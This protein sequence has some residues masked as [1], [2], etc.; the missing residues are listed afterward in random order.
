MRIDSVVSERRRTAVAAVLA[1]VGHAAAAVGLAF[2][3]APHAFFSRDLRG[4]DTHTVEITFIEEAAFA[5]GAAPSGSA[6]G[7]VPPSVPGYTEDSALQSDVAASTAASRMNVVT[8]TTAALALQPS[9][10]PSGSN[11]DAARGRAVPPTAHAVESSGQS[12]SLA[13]LGLEPGS[14]VALPRRNP[15]MGSKRSGRVLDAEARL[16]RS[17][18]EGAAT[19]D[20]NLGLGSHGA[21][22]S[23]LESTTLGASTPAAGTALFVARVDSSGKLTFLDVVESNGATAGWADVARRTRA[24]LSARR[25]RV[26]AGGRGV[27]LK[28]RVRSRVQMPSGA[29]PGLEVRALGIPLK[30]GEGKRSA[31]IEILTPHV[32]AKMIEVPNPGNPSETLELPSLQLGLGVFGMFGDPSDIGAER[33]RMVS[34]VVESQRA[35]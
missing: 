15:R 23:S 27:E 30:R 16:S 33:Q 13:Q 20:L 25:L 8:S 1:V 29:D 28:I 32:D 21:I 26:P 3:H 14:N 10:A 22:L 5:R 6:R 35:L 11:D 17:L 31:R 18:A 9:L 34:A 4:P 7:D 2:T 19:R 12:L 24:M